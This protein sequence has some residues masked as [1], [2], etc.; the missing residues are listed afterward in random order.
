MTSFVDVCSSVATLNDRYG[1]GGSQGRR[2]TC[3]DIVAG[4][5][6]FMECVRYLNTRRS[7]GAVLRLESEAD[8]QDAVYLMLRPWITDLHW[9]NPGDKVAS[10]YAIK[11]FISTNARTVVEA[12]YIRDASHGK[13]VSKELHDDIEMYRRHPACDHIVFFL[14]DPQALIPDRRALISAIEAPRQYG[15]HML[16]CHAVVLP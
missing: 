7:D 8:V 13:T 5:Q 9:E 15:D 14:Y 11:D 4:L 10:R 1:V 2:V 3:M 12:K 6:E 16:A